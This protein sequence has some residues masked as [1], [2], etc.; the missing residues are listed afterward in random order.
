MNRYPLFNL[1]SALE[2]LDESEVSSSIIEARISGLSYKN[3]D[4]MEKRLPFIIECSTKNK[5]YWE[6]LV[7]SC[8]KIFLSQN[9]LD[10]VLVFPQTMDCGCI[11]TYRLRPAQ[12]TTISEAFEEK[13]CR[14]PNEDA[15][16]KLLDTDV[17][18]HVHREWLKHK[19]SVHELPTE[20][21]SGRMKNTSVERAMIVSKG[22]GCVSCGEKATCYAATTLGDTSQAFMLQLPVCHQHLEEAKNHPSIFSFFAALFSLQLDWSE[23]EKLPHIQDELIP[24]IQMVVAEELEGKIGN[25]KKTSRGWEVWIELSSG[26][27]WL[28]RLNSFTDFAYMLFEPGVKDE[29]YR[30]D[31]APD[32]PELNF[33]PVHEHSNPNKKKDTVAP[34]YLYGHPLFDLKRFKSVGKDFGAY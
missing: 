31:S 12:K 8:E 20:L 29:R 34:S 15:M 22:D 4:F 32:H 3:L 16:Y 13:T 18:R 21:V 10:A 14:L 27:R 1:D 2:P 17:H 33:F 28:L 24:I 9:S 25:A 6:L 23:I 5:K 30:S 19:D 7:V 11:R 26:W